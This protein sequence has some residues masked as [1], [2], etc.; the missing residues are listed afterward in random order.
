MHK[1]ISEQDQQNVPLIVVR[2]NS[3]FV[4]WLRF[5]R[6]LAVA[7]TVLSTTTTI[8]AFGQQ[9]EV[10]R[11]TLQEGQSIRDVAQEHL[12]DPDLWLEILHFNNLSSVME[13]QPGLALKIPTGIIANA[14]QALLESLTLIQEA[15]NQ[16]ARLF[17]PKLIS[18]AVDLRNQALQQRKA[19]QW[20]NCAQ[21]AQDAKDVAQRALDVT[22]GHRD[23]LAEAVLSD[24]HGSVQGRKSAELVWSTRILN[25][26]LVE[27]E[28][29]RTLS[30]ST[31]QI[32]FLD[33]SR[34]RL[35]E[36]SQA[37]IQRMRLD[38]LQRTEE[39]KVTLVEGDLYALLTGKSKRK[40]FALEVPGVETSI[41]STKFWASRDK[42]TAK[43]TNYD[44]RRLQVSSQGVSVAL[45]KNQ[46][47]VVHQRQVPVA[48]VK[49]LPSPELDL[50]LDGKQ[51]FRNTLALS[52]SAV[53]K[54]T[55][56]WLEVALDPTFKKMVV[57]RWGLMQ[58]SFQ[59]QDLEPGLYYWRVASLD[60][61]GLP[62]PWGEV[63]RFRIHTDIV[64]PYL[65]LRSPQEKMIIRR[66]PV[67]VSGETE[68][69]AQLT[70]NGKPIK[71]DG[72]GA[73]KAQH[74]LHRGVNELVV[75]A[76][77][78]VGN[79]TRR[80]RTVIFMPDRTVAIVYDP[81]LPQIEPK[82]FVARENEFS[83][84][85]TTAPQ[86]K[87]LVRSGLDAVRASTST[88]AAG[89]FRVNVPIRGVRQVFTLE[90]IM[91]SGFITRDRIV[92]SVDRQP[93]VI[94]L[95]EWP[96]AVTAEAELALRGQINGAQNMVLNGKSIELQ[97][98]HFE[99]TIALESGSNQI[100][101]MASDL[102]G[103][104]RVE[105]W[106]VTLDQDPPKL[107]NHRISDDHKADG[108]RIV[109]EV[110]AEDAS[111]LRQVAAFA[112]K[113]GQFVFSDYL[114]L[115]RAVQR[116]RGTL[117]LPHYAQGEVTLTN[118]ELEDYLG[119][120]RRYGF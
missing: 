43:F 15:T 66:Q 21:L 100:Q 56:Y 110:E 39:A 63:R 88:D 28:R 37:V 116:Y 50:P 48:A 2:T 3:Q 24:R 86:A 97:D 78:S 67:T 13:I 90:V 98:Q 22:L 103:N 77:D 111:S 47:T 83:L 31:G 19:S 74:E 109:I 93:P 120:R 52:W 45:G 68:S 42:R 85:G 73:F 17:A 64:P 10:L 84:A 105:T 32:T 49:L 57:S 61:F 81:A 5:L 95:A 25:A 101:M 115:D 92:L 58:S 6:R 76:T 79:P 87:I 7:V 118:I 117:V 69:D 113:V 106:Q 107:L 14:N 75:E 72:R 11:I 8:P 102:V 89:R 70:L 99:A 54:A 94:Q 16:G 27:E 34:L 41:D 96:P 29:I 112:V 59:A 46:G 33:E 18:D 104:V 9:D 65:L 108:G 91:P 55:G 35:N 12:A 36:N 71:V 30:R 51:V 53:A 23:K 26:I 80:S 40:Q 82:H 44:D 114:R 119:N 38:P 60:Q 4:Y 62:S 20:D 1:G